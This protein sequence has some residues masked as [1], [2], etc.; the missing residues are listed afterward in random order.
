MAVTAKSTRKVVVIGWDLD[1]VHGSHASIQ[2]QGEE[3]R[4]VDNDG[5]TNLFFPLNFNGEIEVTVAGS[6]DGS[7]TGTIK[8]R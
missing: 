2:V 7:D 6:K 4:N 5:T 1:E 8:V 3:K